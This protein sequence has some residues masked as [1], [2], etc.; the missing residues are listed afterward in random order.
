MVDGPHAVLLCCGRGCALI[1]T[2]NFA[3]V[4]VGRLCSPQLDPPGG[5]VVNCKRKTCIN[6][7]TCFALVLLLHAQVNS[8]F[9]KKEWMARLKVRRCEQF[10]FSQLYQGAAQR[11]RPFVVVVFTPSN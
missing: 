2:L 6:S 3:T 8:V 10:R 11:S 9:T 7:K 5:S 4:F 1:H